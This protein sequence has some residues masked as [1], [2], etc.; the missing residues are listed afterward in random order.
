MPYGICNLSI[1]PL[2]L[3]PSD[4]SELTSQ[5]LYGEHFK[6][7]EQRKSWSKIRLSFDEYEC[8]IDN[9]HYIDIS[10]D[11]CKAI[12]HSISKRSCNFVEYVLVTNNLFLTIPL[13][14]SVHASE[15]LQHHFEGSY[16]VDQQ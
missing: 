6:I 2:R 15:F 1:V 11:E 8:W 5:V 7:L 12:E 10:M 4:T 3:D 14:A 13:G 9:N 16:L